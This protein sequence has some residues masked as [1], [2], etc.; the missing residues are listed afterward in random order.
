MVLIYSFPEE[1]NVF[2]LNEEYLDK[3]TNSIYELRAN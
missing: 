1:N 2:K 3:K